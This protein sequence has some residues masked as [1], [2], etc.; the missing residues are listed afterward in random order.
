MA[1]L[2]RRRDASSWRLARTIEVDIWVLSVALIWA[3][4]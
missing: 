4:S 2:A 3:D 1:W